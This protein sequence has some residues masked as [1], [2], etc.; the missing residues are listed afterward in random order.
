MPLTGSRYAAQ[1]QS[2]S[3]VFKRPRRVA[4]PRPT[5]EGDY[6]ETPPVFLNT[7]PD[8]SLDFTPPDRGGS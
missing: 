3:R 6:R 7:R 5:W 2:K 4:G 1:Q 8:G